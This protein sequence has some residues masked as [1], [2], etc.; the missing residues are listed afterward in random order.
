MAAIKDL[1]EQLSQ[2]DTQLNENNMVKAVSC[3]D[4]DTFLYTHTAR[5]ERG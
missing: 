5:I 3:T 1:V 2:Y 4:P